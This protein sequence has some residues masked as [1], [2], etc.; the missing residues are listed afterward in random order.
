MDT[1]AWTHLIERGVG[2]CLE[3]AR[4]TAPP[5]S[6][7][8]I[9]GR[10]GIT[11]IRDGRLASRGRCTR[12][13]GRPVIAVA[14]ED[15]PERLEWTI[16]HELG[17][18][19][20]PE[21]LADRPDLVAS[22]A[23]H[24]R[25]REQVANL[26]A[27]RLLLPTPWFPEAWRETDGDLLALKDRFT[28]ASHELIAWRMLDASPHSIISI[29]DQGRLTRRRGNGAASAPPLHALEQTLLARLAAH[30]APLSL[31]TDGLTATGWPIDEP[32]WRR[33]I[34]RLSADD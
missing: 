32:G 22:L 5:V 6:P 10:L 30:R 1:Q 26:F 7:L 18:I 23:E 31:A 8:K 11:I 2:R 25:L 14:D 19:A 17:E 16:A 28:T 29:F 9:A 21:L 24:D 34:L 27:T 13:E 15:R 12:L 3:R 20:F 33:D 4:W